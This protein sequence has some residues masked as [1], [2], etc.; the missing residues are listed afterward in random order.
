MSFEILPNR[1]EMTM[2]V[3]K[4]TIETY[5]VDEKNFF[6]K[7]LFDVINCMYMAW[8]SCFKKYS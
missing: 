2:V 3:M 5:T 4:G 8:M 7:L 1:Q 6:F